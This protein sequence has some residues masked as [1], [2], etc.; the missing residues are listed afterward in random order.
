MDM[1]YTCV[2]N[3]IQMRAIDDDNR[4]FFGLSLVSISLF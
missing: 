3:I 1:S 2:T 4:L